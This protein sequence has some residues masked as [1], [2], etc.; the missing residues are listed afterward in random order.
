[1]KKKLK[2]GSHNSMTYLK[3]KKWWMYP[4]RFI[5][6]CQSKSIEEQYEKYGIRVFDLRVSYDEN[7]CIE[8][9]HGLM[10]FRGDV[11]QV[12]EYLNS[13]KTKVYVRLLLEVGEY[14]DLERQEWLFT[15]DCE[16]FE[17]NY[18]NIKFFCGRRK[19]DWKEVYKFRFKEPNII[20]KVSSMQGNKLDDLW[21]WLYAKLHNKKSLEE[22]KEGWL[23]LDFIE[24]Q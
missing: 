9:R 1:M 5:A 11:R 23:F 12:L 24:I 10:S 22:V 2:L 18:P 17:K 4:F 20:Q 21:P 7:S 6:K 13:R 3:P 19:F 8:F 15:L 14:A 16:T